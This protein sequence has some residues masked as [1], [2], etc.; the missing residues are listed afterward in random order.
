M[1]LHKMNGKKQSAYDIVKRHYINEIQPT[2]LRQNYPPV[3]LT[4]HKQPSPLIVYRDNL[5]PL[6]LTTTHKA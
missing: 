1:A 5:S 2:H 6:C 3:R 4:R